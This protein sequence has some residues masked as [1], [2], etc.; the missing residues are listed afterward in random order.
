MERKHITITERHAEFISDLNL[1][2]SG[3]VRDKLDD[4]IEDIDWQSA[5]EIMTEEQQNT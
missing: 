2:L 5:E 1:Q 3:I 4:M